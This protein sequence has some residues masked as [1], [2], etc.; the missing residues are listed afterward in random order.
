MPSDLPLHQKSI[1][2]FIADPRARKKKA[3]KDT[4]YPEHPAARKQRRG[5]QM[6]KKMGKSLGENTVAAAADQHRTIA[7]PSN[8]REDHPPR[9]NGRNKTKSPTKLRRGAVWR[10]PTLEIHGSRL[11]LF[12]RVTDAQEMI[13]TDRGVRAGACASV[14]GKRALTKL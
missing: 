3:A 13:L 4:K 9:H 11:R 2:L 6:R 7:N 8:P 12:K 14:G 5:I 10:V 1:S